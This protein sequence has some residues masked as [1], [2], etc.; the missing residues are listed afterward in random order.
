[1]KPT[2]NK[3]LESQQTDL[4]RAARRL[5]QFAP[6]TMVLGK[7]TGSASIDA[8]NA[9]FLY[10]WE[11]AILNNTNGAASKSPGIASTALSI[12]ELSNGVSGRYS[13]GVNPA[14]LVGTF[15]PVAI[16]NGTFVLLTPMRQQNGNLRWLI[17]NTQAI[18]GQCPP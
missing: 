9:R 7:I 11:E 2:F 8:P 14:N 5:D 16:P 3:P 18:D 4:D 1:M 12:S 6:R 17:I 10:S 13:Y 15:N